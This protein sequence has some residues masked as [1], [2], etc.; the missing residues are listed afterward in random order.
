MHLKVKINS[1]KKFCTLFIFLLLVFGQMAYAQAHKVRGKVLDENGQGLP[2]AG[3]NIKNTQMGTVTDADGNFTIEMPE[4]DNVLVVHAIGYAKQDVTIT[5]NGAIV[6]M[7]VEAKALKETVI[8][9]LG[10][11]KEKKRLGYSISEVNSEDVYK[12]GENNVVEALAGKTSGVNVTSSA[13]TPGASS[14]ITLRG[15][16]SLQGETQPLTVVDGIVIDNSTAQAVAGDYAFNANLSGVNASNRALD[17]NPDDIE[18]IS[19][20]KG[21]E[22]AA[23]YG[24][25]GGNGAI[26]ITTKRGHYRKKGEKTLGITYRSSVEMTTV[27][28]LPGIQNQ[29]LQGN[30]GKLDTS[31]NTPNSW[32][33]AKDTMPGVK[34]YNKY[35][36]FF[37]TGMGYTNNIAIEGGNENNI[38]RVSYG[39]YT[40]TGV[41]PNSSMKRN[42]VTLFGE[43]KQSSWLTVGG[44]ANYSNTQT[45]MVQN[46]STLGGVMLTLLRAPIN[47]NINNYINPLTGYQTQYYSIYDNPLFTAYKNPYNDQTDRFY[48][49]LYANAK[50]NDNWSANWKVGSDVYTTQSRQ[51]YAISSYGDD[52]NDQ[53]GQVNYGTAYNKSIYSDFILH[54]DKHLSQN[55]EF[56]SLVGYNFWYLESSTEFARGRVL[57]VPDFYNL[58]N[59]AQLYASNSFSQ[60]RRQGVYGDAQLG[61]KSFLY[62]DIT[63]RNDWTTAFGPNGRSLFYPKADLSWLF[64]EHI[65]KNDW[66][67]YG[68]LRF[69]YSDAGAGPNPY[70]YNR[71]TYYAVPTFTD[72]YTNGNSFPYLGQPGYAASN[73][74]YP[75]DLKPADIE[76]REVGLELRMFKN[77]VSFTGVYYNQISHNNLILQPVA[78]SSGYQYQWA[79]GGDLQNKGVELE[80]GIDIIKNKNFQWNIGAN[81]TKNV[82]KVLSL[83]SNVNDINIESG[84]SEI[85]TQAF[86]GQPVGVFYGTAWERDP[87][88]GKIL[89]DD[90]G[91]AKV[92]PIQRIIG[93]P[94]PDW[95]MNI[96]N[97]FSYKG[98]NFSFLI[99]IRHGG[100]IWNGTQ[101]RLNNVGVSAASADRNQDFVLPNAEYASTGGADTTHVSA[102]YYWRTFKGDRGNYAAENAIQDGSWVR[103]RAVNI[104]YR[105]NFRKTNPNSTIQYLELGLTAR[106]LILITNYTGVDPETSLTGAGSNLSGYDY[107]NNPGTKSYMVNLRMG[108]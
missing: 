46:G 87:K 32:G 40:T 96:N 72:G 92:D 11:K 66:I 54:Y 26:I 60:E 95:L 59:A 29:F 20:L 64:S 31:G 45:Q 103:L 55:L 70:T 49:N 100:D 83:P 57:A 22:A 67:G 25:L 107:F 15:T 53:L 98:F 3:V 108:L 6:H 8:T 50:I 85:L 19:V 42:N 99:D 47:Y 39:N 93:N 105:F 51:I 69:A 73:T 17:I 79:N 52:N 28:Q 12:S 58:S 101:A 102:S 2:G 24:S 91:L 71:T 37:K 4:G 35:S 48:G 106:N 77:R 43:S 86:V 63:G 13:G 5:G 75:G 10:I 30:G 97:S 90:N 33:A 34:T 41:I 1:M 56:N 76:G 80:L 88:N 36:D 27:S 9:A 104:S 68:K 61:Y 89:V 23:L 78:P 74:Y 62:L 21:P 44:S 14:K 81:F 65:P 38:F 84:F 16:S 18:S 94:N 7:K 82:N